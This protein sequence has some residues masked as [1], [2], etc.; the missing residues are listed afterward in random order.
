MQKSE[1][2]KA[3]SDMWKDFDSRVLRYKVLP[4]LCAELRNVVM[5]PMILPMVLTIAE[6]QEQLW[7]PLRGIGGR[8]EKSKGWIK[9]N[10]E[11]RRM[12]A[13]KYKSTKNDA[14]IMVK[15]A[16]TITLEHFYAELRDI[17]GDKS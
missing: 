12:N 10:K 8:M 3:L 15:M 14:K 11:E 4:P 16:K 17:G 6:S 7:C 2:L 13:E 5:Q 9:K 1:F